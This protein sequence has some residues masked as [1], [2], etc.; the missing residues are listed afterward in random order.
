MIKPHKEIRL[1]EKLF[2]RFKAGDQGAFRYLFDSYYEMLVGFCKQFVYDADK[3]QSLAQDAFVSLWMKRDKIKTL[4]GV[5]SFLYTSAKCSCID[6]LRHSKVVNR[7]KDAELY[8]LEKEMN[9]EVLKSLDFD[10]LVYSEMEGQVQRAIAN[11]PER[12]REVFLLKREGNKKNREIAEELN[13]SVKAVEANM[14]R[15]IKGL[16]H[17]LSYF[18]GLLLFLFSV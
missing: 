4:A 14:A 13:I 17:A 1:D 12:S 10:S 18:V 16:K 3:A 8:R 5:K 2:L 15:A 9:L 11:L 7:Y 6:L